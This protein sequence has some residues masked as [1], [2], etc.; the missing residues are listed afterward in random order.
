MS[1]TVVYL[2]GICISY[3]LSSFRLVEKQNIRFD[4]NL[5]AMVM[6]APPPQSPWH[7]DQFLHWVYRQQTL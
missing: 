5:K 4:A 7:L 1:L 6:L 3:F 2:H